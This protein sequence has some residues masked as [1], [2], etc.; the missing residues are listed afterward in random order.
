M[1]QEHGVARGSTKTR[2]IR[3][4]Q[5]MALDQVGS[6]AQEHGVARGSTETLSQE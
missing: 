2:I 5:S 3:I 6:M 1:A 4:E